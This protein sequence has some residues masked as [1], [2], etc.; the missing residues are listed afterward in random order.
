MAETLNLLFQK[1][2]D[3][4]FELQ[5]RGSWSG[6]F[7]SGSFI[8]PYNSRQLNTLLKRLN[9]LESDQ[10]ELRE[11]GHRL[12][13]ALC[14]SETPGAGRHEA[15]EQ[16]VQAMWRSVIQR[17]LH[18]RATVALTLCFG[19]GCEEF[20]RYPWELL[21]NDEHFLLASGV[22]TLTR[23]IL[24]PDGPSECALPVYPPLRLLYIGASPVDCPA[25]E[26]ERSFEALERGLGRLV[27]DGLL[28]ID[29]LE[30]ATFDKLVRYLTS[31]GGVNNFNDN[32]TPIPCYA[33]HFDGHGAYGR[34]C[35][36]DDCDALNDANA[37]RCHDCDTSLKGTRPQTYL[38]FC[39]D[40]GRNRLI[41][42][43]ALRELLVSSDVRLAVF[44][45]CETATLSGTGGTEEKRR[46]VVDATLATALLMAQVPAVVAMPFSLQDDLSPTFMYHFYDDLANGRTLE[47]ALA[48]AR[49]AMLPLSK[50]HGWFVPVLYRH[51]VE[52]TRDR[53][54]SWHSR[55]R[56]NQMSAIIPW[57][58][59]AL[60]PRLS[61]AN[62]RWRP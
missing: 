45:A 50:A 6:R 15:I 39:D 49:Q 56:T 3:E 14:G 10:R 31:L 48:R 54:L 26:T 21:H 42:T 60:R 25:L 2:D 16:S 28:L 20:V 57:L 17:T 43:S 34:L 52:G 36:A 5:V 24:R 13:Q 58:T 53:W 23:A 30:P 46:A 61:G 4:T 32:E 33:I 7:V 51:V 41:D 19:P 55:R 18:R 11:I 47:S 8:P 27:D 12:F 35:P 22:F 1:R 59:W 37:Q 38:C 62:R 9:N 40:E 29:R 44:S